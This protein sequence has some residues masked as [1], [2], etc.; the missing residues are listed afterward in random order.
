M[1]SEKGQTKE[2]ER[3]NVITHAIGF[4]F[5]VIGSCYLLSLGFKEGIHLRF[6]TYLVFCIGLVTLYLASTLYHGS[7]DPR[8]K[9]QLNIFDHSAIYLLIAGTYTPLTLLTIKGVWGFAIF[10]VVWV[11]AIVGIVMKLYFTGR[12]PKISTAIYVLM[13]WVILIAIKPLINSM[14]LPGLLWLLVGGLFY[15]F[16]ALLYQ[17][18]SVKYNHVV[19]H[20]F[21]IL[22]S[23]CHYI[24]ILSY[25]N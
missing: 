2:E 15:T 20:I 17:W 24:V 5:A 23:I 8:R 14:I 13:G 12:F 22:G 21:V 18:K 1:K 25:T 19:F 16:G 6:I 3:L 11:I 4:V 9:K 7:T 10:L